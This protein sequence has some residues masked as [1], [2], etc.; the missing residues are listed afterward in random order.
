M[1]K[2]VFEVLQLG[3]THGLTVE[4]ASRAG[5]RR[6]H[7]CL[8]ARQ[9]LKKRK[10]P[11]LNESIIAEIEDDSDFDTEDSDIIDC[12]DLQLQERHRR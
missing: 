6:F 10:L 2:L 12:K 7:Q 3:Q 5:N 1:K 8:W 4:E 11:E 9:A